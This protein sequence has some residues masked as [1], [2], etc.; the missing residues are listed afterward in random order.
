[1][2]TASHP[3]YADNV[4]NHIDPTGE[5]IQHRFYRQHC[6]LQDDV[7][8]KDLRIFKNVSLKEIILVDNAV[9]SFGEQLENGIP[10][11]PFKEDPRDTEFLNLIKYLDKI[12]DVEDVREYN[13]KAFSLRKIFKTNLEPFIQYYDFEECERML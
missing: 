11:T 5:L 8:V 1:V 2:F 4:I 3:G 10:I 7:Y 6:I 12:K 13:N 9:Y